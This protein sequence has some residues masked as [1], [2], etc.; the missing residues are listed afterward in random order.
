[1]S[2]LIGI[3]PYAA[4]RIT[5]SIYI[6]INYPRSGFK[7]ENAEYAYDFGSYFVDL[8]IKKEKMLELC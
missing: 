4:A 8:V 6:A 3:L 5:S 1:V 7:F 2:E